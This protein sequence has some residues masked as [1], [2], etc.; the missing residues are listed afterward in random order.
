MALN[1]PIL[2]SL[3][4]SGFDKA[5]R[6]FGKLKTVS[7]KSAY[8]I[9]K[10]AVPAAAALAGL[11]VALGDA[12]KSAIED[13]A[14]QKLLASALKKTTGATDAQI[15][16]NENWI[17]AQGKLLGVTDDELRPVINR[18]SRATG[19]LTKAQ[20]LATQAMDIAAAT[21]IPLPPL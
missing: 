8:A 16:A 4:T 21:G 19:D 11:G 13:D 7:E 6:E 12:A 18:F 1:I 14:A 2:S 17:T 5:A 9:K 10:A 20:Q 3:D 15:A